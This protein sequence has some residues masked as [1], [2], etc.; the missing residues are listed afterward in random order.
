MTTCRVCPNEVPPDRRTLCSKYCE[1][2]Y[3]RRVNRAAY[4]RRKGRTPPPEKRAEPK[5][6]RVKMPAGNWFKCVYDGDDNDALL[7][8]HIYARAA[9]RE[10][11]LHGANVGWFQAVG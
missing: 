11:V 9:V 6:V 2:E 4:Y 3:N 8:H 1:D 5:P 10:F 7:P